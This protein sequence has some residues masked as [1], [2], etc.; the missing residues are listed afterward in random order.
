MSKE[1]ISRRD[2][3]RGAAA[4]AAAAAASAVLPVG[5]ASAE[6]GGVYTPGTYSAKAYGLW[7]DVTVTMTFDESSILDVVIDASGETEDIGGAAAATLADQI[8]A[9][10]SAE[11]DGVSGATATS[12]AVMKAAAQ[13][14][15]EA[16][17][18]D[19]AAL[20]GGEGADGDLMT[21]EKKEKEKWAFEIAPDPIPDDQ[22]SEVITHDVIVIGA[23]MSGLCCA[24][25][26]QHFG[27]DVMLFSASSIPYARGG[28]NHAIG[29]K[30]QKKLGVDYTPDTARKMVKVEQ[31][32]G[33]YHMNKQTWANWVNNSAESMDFMID[34]MEGQG[35][36]VGLE[37]PYIDP[38]DII[39]T[40]PAS[41]NFYSDEQPF[42]VFYGA[43]LCA[44][45]YADHFTQHGG[46]IMYNVTA[47]QLV[48]DDN[49]TGRVSAVIAQRQSDGKYIK[50]VANKAVVM[51]TGDFS[52][53]R[54]M[55]AKYSPW[56]YEHFKDKFTWETNYDNQFVYSGLMPGDG[57][58]MG[59]WIGAAWQRTFP[60]P[61]AIN[62][63]AGGPAHAVISN[64][65]GINLDING[66]RF[67]NE[68]TN[69]AYAGMAVLDLPEETAFAVW[70]QDYAYTEEVWDALGAVTDGGNGIP[71]DTP[72]SLIA[73]WDSRFVK[74]DTLEELI[75]ILYEGYSDEAKKT[76][77]ESIANY[78]K[79]AKNGY[80]E[81]FQVNP[82]VLHPIENGPFYGS[83]TV[84]STFLAVFGG[85][86]T[87]DK[88]QV[89]DEHDKPIE[90]LYNVG[91]MIGDFYS[92][93]YNFV[94]PGQNLGACCCTLP[95]LVGKRLGQGEA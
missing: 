27:A 5:I 28:S 39:T 3:L 40:Y 84:G 66:R 88:C 60:N 7:S 11:I 71:E 48:R 81:E 38:D 70:S 13:C 82:K 12:K 15:A 78:T 30:Y 22:I 29:S 34:V 6:G 91:T 31:I 47:K 89:C 50:F 90:G 83:K 35:L 54:D 62:G 44:Q 67:M 9:T 69:F 65:W 2:F 64:F 23:G 68:C 72:E 49:N 55:M 4:A 16:K 77:L 1:K 32:S 14:I 73:G 85:L 17:G 25:S 43:P 52:T 10:Q 95:Y 75:D 33:T 57:Q 26:A 42:G 93:S 92:N 36:H 59:L 20:T 46:E 76:A 8:K 58:K 56:V 80:D 79:Y 45:A 18:V 61:C 51:A 94:L 87:N 74:A 37:A 86:R 63:G 41:H 53:N 24:V 19:V 21:W